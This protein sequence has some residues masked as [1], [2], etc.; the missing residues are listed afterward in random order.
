MPIDEIASPNCDV[1]ETTTPLPLSRE[2]LYDLAWSEPMLKVAARYNVSS[3][4]MA[5]VYT[6]LNVPRPAPG[7]WAKVKA[8]WPAR[9]PP[10]PDP[11]PGDE[12]VWS[13]D[14]QHIDI[15][16]PLPS[17]PSNSPKRRKRSSMP[18][19]T[20]HPLIV[21]AKEH[22][23]TGRLS[24]EGD[25]L[26]PAKKLLI[27]LVVSKTGLDKALSFANDLFLFLEAKGHRVVIAPNNEQFWRADVDEHEEP[28]K[29]NGYNNLWSP[30]RSTVVYIGT[31][32]I[33]LTV[34]EMSEEVKVR[35]VN[36]K[37]IREE[38]YIPPKR[39]PHPY[40]WTTEKISQTVDYVYKPIHLT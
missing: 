27:D 25:Y 14:G 1:K 35:Y 22:F 23:E 6:R 34:I 3:S 13:K 7:Y 40:T 28:R 39:G 10:L 37:F 5:R 36:G 30:W 9:K 18:R 24:H 32:A 4:Y 2:A 21:G 29:N 20:V 8:G 15:K 33:G 16:R 12:V 38:D 19:P 26:K 11:R 31:V 17:P